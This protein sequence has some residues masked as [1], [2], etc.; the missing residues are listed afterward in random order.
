M[1]YIKRTTLI[2]SCL[3]LLGWQFSTR[4]IAEQS[5]SMSNYHDVF[6]GPAVIYGAKHIKLYRPQ[7]RGAESQV[8]SSAEVYVQEPNF[9]T[10]REW[11]FKNIYPVLNSKRQ[12]PMEAPEYCLALSTLQ[13]RNM[14]DILLILPLNRE[15][16]GPDYL[17]KISE[18]RSILNKPKE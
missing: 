3:T 7:R 12:I 6:F 16:L 15:T 10:V 17:E 11:V 14:A 8:E 1:I 13:N 2:I 9:S 4:S 18:L 5:M